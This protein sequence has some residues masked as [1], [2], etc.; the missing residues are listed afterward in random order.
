MAALCAG[1]VLKAAVIKGLAC[2]AMGGERHG[3]VG[4]GCGWWRVRGGGGGGGCPRRGGGSGGAC[5]PVS[6]VVVMYVLNSSCPDDDGFGPA[7]SNAGVGDWWTDG[8]ADDADPFQAVSRVYVECVL[9]G[10]WRRRFSWLLM[11]IGASRAV[12]ADVAS[13]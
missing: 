5:P 1:S 7:V 3:D 12:G 13:G 4:S 2:P 11:M 9:L 6:C 10:L 8:V